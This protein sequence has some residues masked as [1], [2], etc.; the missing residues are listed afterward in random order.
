MARR[1]QDTKMAV[2]LGAAGAAA[3]LAFWPRGQLSLVL[4]TIWDRVAIDLAAR[5]KRPVATVSRVGI[6]KALFPDT[7]LGVTPPPKVSC[8]PVP[9]RGYVVIAH[10]QGY[11]NFE[12]RANVEGTNVVF[13]GAAPSPFP[14]PNVSLP[15]P[16]QA[17]RLSATFA[18]AILRRLPG[19]ERRGEEAATVAVARWWNAVTS[20]TATSRYYY[21]HWG[22]DLA[23]Y[24]AYAGVS[25]ATLPPLPVGS[26]R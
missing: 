26:R 6:R 4:T 21:A 17:S 15:P 11:G 7:C 25:L 2:I 10:S 23:W 24:A 18:E 20:A 19:I 9:V 3:A 13:A 1:D 12:Y 8:I 5:L 14:R 22:F 16:L